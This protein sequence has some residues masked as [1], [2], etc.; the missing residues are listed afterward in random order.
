[1]IYARPGSAG[2]HGTHATTAWILTSSP[3][4]QVSWSRIRAQAR[5]G[6]PPSRKSKDKELPPLGCQHWPRAAWAPAAAGVGPTP[7]RP[8]GGNVTR[9][10]KTG[11]RRAR[12]EEGT[13][14]VRDLRQA[15]GEGLET[16]GRP[17]DGGRGAGEGP[18]AGRNARGLVSRSDIGHTSPA[19]SSARSSHLLPS[20][21]QRF[22]RGFRGWQSAVRQ[23]S[24]L[25][26]A[27]SALTAAHSMPSGPSHRQDTTSA[28]SNKRVSSQGGRL[29]FRETSLRRSR[30]L[31][32]KGTGWP[33]VWERPS[34]CSR[35]D[36]D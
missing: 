6:R 23:S 33:A 28:F 26:A 9:C 10:Q 16:E 25:P 20:R 13:H 36:R 1:M 17:A 18:W 11:Q 27:L 12:Y 34:R 3:L 14:A 30:L 7:L 2:P 31:S 15:A 32:W 24:G 35:A 5:F 21:D 8:T 4:S 19:N 22:A 29:P